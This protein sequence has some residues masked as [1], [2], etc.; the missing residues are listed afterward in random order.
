MKRCINF[1]VNPGLLGS[2]S[3]ELAMEGEL[4]IIQE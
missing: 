1:I 4:V 3:T 2:A